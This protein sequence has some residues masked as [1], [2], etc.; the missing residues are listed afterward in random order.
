MDSNAETLFRYSAGT[1]RSLCSGRSIGLDY[2]PI[3]EDRAGAI[4]SREAIRE[5]ERATNTHVRIIALTAHAMQGDK[6]RFLTAGMDGYLSK[7][8]VRAELMAAL[9]AAQQST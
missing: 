8:I 7:P 2:T 6:E 9:A 3:L 1:I 4:W 5:R